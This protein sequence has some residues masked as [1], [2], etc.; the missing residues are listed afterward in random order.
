MEGI[1]GRKYS[2]IFFG[3]SMATWFGQNT[4]GGTEIA[5]ILGKLQVKK[6]KHNIIFHKYKRATPNKIYDSIKHTKEK[7]NPDVGDLSKIKSFSEKG[8]F[9]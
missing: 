4:K 1:F 3:I 2:Y 9:S 6:L 5:R 7:L 8:G